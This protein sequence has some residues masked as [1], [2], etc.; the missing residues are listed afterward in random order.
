M[1]HKPYAQRS[2]RRPECRTTADPGWVWVSEAQGGASAG[3]RQQEGTERQPSRVAPEGSCAS[4]NAVLA[5]RF[6]P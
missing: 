5:E 1:T 3:L 2:C 4:N 6:A